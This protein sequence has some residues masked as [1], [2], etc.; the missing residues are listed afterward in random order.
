MIALALMFPI[1]LWL[2]I[3]AIAM[4]V[5]YNETLA[6]RPGSKYWI[7]TLEFREK[8]HIILKKRNAALIQVTIVI[9]I[10]IAIMIR[11]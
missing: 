2:S 8:L 7:K 10:T 9:T 5:L 6:S 11:G 3:K 1:I 4:Q